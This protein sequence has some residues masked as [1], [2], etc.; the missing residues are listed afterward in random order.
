MF[1][2]P[3]RV[4]HR[5]QLQPGAPQRLV[6]V[7]RDGILVGIA[8][9]QQR[10]DSDTLYGDVDVLVTGLVLFAGGGAEDGVAVVLGR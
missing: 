6:E 3:H 1:G 4:V 9:V 2:G 7:L 5:V 10:L 8:R